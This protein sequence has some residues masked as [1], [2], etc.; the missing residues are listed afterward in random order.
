LLF[1]AAKHNLKIVDLPIRY[2]ER[3]YGDT[4]IQRWRHGVILLRMAFLAMRRIKFV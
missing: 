2:A 4:N 1:G 3:T